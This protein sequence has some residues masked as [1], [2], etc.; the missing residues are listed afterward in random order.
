MEL[1]LYIQFRETDLKCLVKVD[2]RL[3][4]CV[5][6][7]PC[8]STLS[9]VDIIVKGATR[10]FSW[11]WATLPR[12]ETVRLEVA[13]LDQIDV[14]NGLQPKLIIVKWPRIKGQQILVFFLRVFS[15]EALKITNYTEEWIKYLAK[16]KLK[17]EGNNV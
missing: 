17:C 15:H 1:A 6:P 4:P 14:A 8:L 9:E 16:Y 11:E 3:F 10:S 7:V 5:S 13:H 2:S 12:L